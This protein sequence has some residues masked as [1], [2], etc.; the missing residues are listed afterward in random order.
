M[1]FKHYCGHCDGKFEFRSSVGFVHFF[2]HSVV[3]FCA[4]QLVK[5]LQWSLLQPPE[6]YQTLAIKNRLCYDRL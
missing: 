6:T 1:C 4:L 2:L 3:K 5:C